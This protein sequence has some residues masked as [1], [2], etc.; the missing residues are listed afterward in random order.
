MKILLLD[1]ETAPNKAYVW[2]LW[3]QNISHE[4]IEESGYILCWSAKWLDDKRVQFESCQKQSHKKM[5]RGIHDL[6][7][8]ADV[9]VHYYGSK[10][11]IP[12][13]NR[14]F[15]KH[16]FPPP[17]PYKQIDL[18]TMVA[19]V[20]KFESN[21]L[22][23]VAGAL[24]LGAKVSHEGFTLWTK[25]MT[26]DAQAWRDMEGYNKGDVALL[27]KLYRRLQPWIEKHPNWSAATRTECCPKCGSQEY[28][29]R[30]TSVALTRTYTRYQCKSCGGWFRG[31]RSVGGAV[32]TNIGA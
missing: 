25:C 27:E 29:K 20:F 16:G 23:Y 9:V 8:D 4:H 30:G 21:K 12:V 14:E 15:A 1:I 24:G 3:E 2:G 32:T 13:L 28:Q 19:R 17:S 31:V 7:N 22:A 10:F 26:G 6:L 18:K 5:L 11:D